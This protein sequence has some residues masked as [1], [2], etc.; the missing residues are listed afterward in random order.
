MCRN[1]G[2]AKRNARAFARETV[3]LLRAFGEPAQEVGETRAGMV[4]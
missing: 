2:E 3:M 4:A 1:V